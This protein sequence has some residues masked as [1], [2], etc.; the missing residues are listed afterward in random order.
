[1]RA[2]HRGRGKT[3]EYYYT[4][5]HYQDFYGASSSDGKAVLNGLQD[6]VALRGLPRDA[7]AGRSSRRARQ[8]GDA[9][10][11]EGCARGRKEELLKYIRLQVLQLPLRL[12]LQLGRAGRLPE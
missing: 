1:M 12:G 7:L 4:D 3:G 6:P 8:D 2:P 9:V 5:D 11:G 10:G